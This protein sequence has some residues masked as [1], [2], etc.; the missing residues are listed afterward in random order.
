MNESIEMV[1]F[2]G[3]GFSN[4]SE[5]LFKMGVGSGKR[6]EGD[7]VRGKGRGNNFREPVLKK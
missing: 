1:W 4:C 6:G 3:E 7:G 2:D 5:F